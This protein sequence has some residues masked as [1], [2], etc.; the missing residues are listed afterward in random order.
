MPM[1]IYTASA[2]R[3]LGEIFQLKGK[4]SF[5]LDEIIVPV[6]IVGQ[7]PDDSLAA[8]TDA[9]WVMVSP[10]QGGATN[11]TV[12]LEND[13]VGSVIL[14]D[15]ITLSGASTNHP[16]VFL[17]VVAPTNASAGGSADKTWNDNSQTPVVPGTMFADLDA[18]VGPVIWDNR[19]LGNTP[20]RLKVNIILQP[21][22][23]IGIRQ[24]TTNQ[25]IAATLNGRVVAPFAA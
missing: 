3:R 12:L 5:Q 13:S 7:E 22:Q 19:T 15:R 10:A 25:E 14:I 18:F 6:V 24:A 11:T 16:Q 20:Y 4:T 8:Q 9:T 21:G 23:L 17:T 1:R 2:A